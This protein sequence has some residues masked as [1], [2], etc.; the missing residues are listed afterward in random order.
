M[1]KNVNGVPMMKLNCRIK[2]RQIKLL[3][4]NMLLTGA[5]EVFM[6][7]NPFASELIQSITLKRDKKRDRYNLFIPAGI[8]RDSYPQAK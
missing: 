2:D 7:H 6:S 1:M 3:M 8:I 4:F 5:R